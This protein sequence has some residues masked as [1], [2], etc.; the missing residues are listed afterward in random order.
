MERAVLESPRISQA[1]KQLL[2]AGM[3]YNPV[4]WF[5]MIVCGPMDE[6]LGV[7]YAEPVA[8]LK[9]R[10]SSQHWSQVSQEDVDRAKQALGDRLTAMWITGRQLRHWYRER[11]VLAGYDH[12]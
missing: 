11:A 7:E 2:G 6:E 1:L 4:L 8:V 10:I 9:V 12:E 5:R 3:A